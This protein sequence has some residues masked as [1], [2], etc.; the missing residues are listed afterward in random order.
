M[1][2]PSRNWVV[3]RSNASLSSFFDYIYN[4]DLVSFKILTLDIPSDLVFFIWL[5]DIEY[6]I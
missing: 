2:P 4:D 6:I 5:Q 1:D 3:F